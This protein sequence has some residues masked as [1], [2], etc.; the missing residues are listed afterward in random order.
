MDTDVEVEYVCVEDCGS[1]VDQE[2][3]I[4]DDCFDSQFCERCGEHKDTTWDAFC[5]TCVD[6]INEEYKIDEDEDEDGPASISGLKL[7]LIG[8]D[9][10]AYSILGAASKALKNKDPEMYQ[11]YYDEA[12]SGDYNHLLMITMRYFDVF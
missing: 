7:Q 9:G 6:D 5:N 1:I 4:C 3:I 2:G 10:N 11:K 12:T 8:R